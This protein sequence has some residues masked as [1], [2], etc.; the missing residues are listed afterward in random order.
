[1]KVIK[2]LLDRQPLVSAVLA[3][4]LVLF[5]T[6]LSFGLL[7]G[8][9][10]APNLAD[11]GARL[12]ASLLLVVI[13]VKCDAPGLAGFGATAGNPDQYRW[14]VMMLMGVAVPLFFLLNQVDVATLV[15]TPQRLFA[16]LLRNFSAGL[17][18][19]LLFR[20]ACFYLLY[21]A[22]GPSRGGL[23]RAATSQALLFSALHLVNVSENGVE[24]VLFQVPRAALAGIGF[25][26]LLVCTRSIWPAVFLHAA[27]NATGSMASFFAGPTYSFPDES[28]L[29]GVLK[30]AVMFLFIG[31]PGLWCLSRASIRIHNTGRSG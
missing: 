29:P 27:I 10:G 9:F 18:E 3:I 19:E 16:W 11:V 5:L 25:A 7:R 14:A 13:L 4:V 12:L 21:R 20:G 8:V 2:Y 15:F 31:L 28:G 22:W 24:A 17:W 26:G 23:F 6:S 1:M 30:M